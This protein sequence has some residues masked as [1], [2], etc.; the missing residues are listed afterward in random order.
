[1]RKDQMVGEPSTNS[2]PD[3]C[4]RSASKSLIGMRITCS[5]PISQPI[6]PNRR[7][8]SSSTE[9]SRVRPSSSGTGAGQVRMSS[10]QVS[11]MPG[12][13]ISG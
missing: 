3:T 12:A 7:G 9:P 2:S 4:D 5:R 1:M 13:P 8:R 10:T 11:A 6:F